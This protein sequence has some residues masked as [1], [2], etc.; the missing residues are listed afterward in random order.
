MKEVKQILAHGEMSN[1]V[2]KWA[3]IPNDKGKIQ[4]QVFILGTAK[5]Y[6]I[7]QFMDIMGNPNVC[8]L[9]KAK[10]MK[11]WIICPTKEIFEEF[12]RLYDANNRTIPDFPNLSTF[13][14]KTDTQ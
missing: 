8:Q 13:N 10:H 7:V 14:H 9:V 2:N 11:N 4:Y 5:K 12:W 3:I 1:L 6:Y